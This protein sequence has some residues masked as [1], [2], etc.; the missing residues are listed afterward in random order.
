MGQ[1]ERIRIYCARWRQVIID[2]RRSI[3]SFD[4]DRKVVL[5]SKKLMSCRK[6]KSK[7]KQK[8]TVSIIVCFVKF[9]IIDLNLFFHSMFVILYKFKLS[10]KLNWILQTLKKN[11][12]EK[13]F[14]VLQKYDFFCL[15][16]VIIIKSIFFQ[17][18]SFHWYRLQTNAL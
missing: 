14:F 9:N 16:R 2:F 8:S 17:I 1:S 12:N 6:K 7:T 5:L 10:F 3:N 18:K 13:F 4:F 11:E 15:I